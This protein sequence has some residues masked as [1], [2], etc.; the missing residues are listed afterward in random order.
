MKHMVQQHL[1]LSVFVAS[2]QKKKKLHFFI[3]NRLALNCSFCCNNILP[4]SNQEIV[5]LLFKKR[6]DKAT[7]LL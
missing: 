7:I 5:T 1:M 4:A 2:T 6:Q 3:L